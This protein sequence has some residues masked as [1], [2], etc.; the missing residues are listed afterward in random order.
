M[1]HEVGRVGL[2][3]LGGVGCA[4]YVGLLSVSVNLVTN[5]V[6]VVCELAS[7][8]YEIRTESGTRHGGEI[9]SARVVLATTDD[10]NTTELS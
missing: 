1:D 9:G 6:E 3:N 5:R 2:D 7:Q 8:T 4:N 10:S